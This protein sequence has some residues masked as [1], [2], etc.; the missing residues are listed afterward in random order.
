[1]LSPTK[2]RRARTVSGCGRAAVVGHADRHETPASGNNGPPT[3]PAPAPAAAVVLAGLAAMVTMGNARMSRSVAAG[4]C[5]AVG[6]TCTWFAGFRGHVFVHF[7]GF[8]ALC[9]DPNIS[10]IISDV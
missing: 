9:K 7:K 3:E 5:K 6:D 8:G 1:M 10:P 2:H 4:R